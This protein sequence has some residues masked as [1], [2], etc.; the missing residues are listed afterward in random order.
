MNITG[1]RPGTDSGY[2]ARK[3][4]RLKMKTINRLRLNSPLPRRTFLQLLR[5][6]RKRNR[7]SPV[8]SRS[9]TPA[10]WPCHVCR[11]SSRSGRI[12]LCTC[13]NTK[14][15]RGPCW[16]TLTR[17][18]MW[19]L[20]LS[21]LVRLLPDPGSIVAPLPRYAASC[22]L[23]ER[24]T[25]GFMRWSR[26]P[27]PSCSTRYLRPSGGIRRKT[28]DGEA[29]RGYRSSTSSRLCLYTQNTPLSATRRMYPFLLNFINITSPTPTLHH[30]PIHL[31]RFL[32][33]GIVTWKHNNRCSLL[34]DKHR[35]RRH[36]R[37]L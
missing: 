36:S 1:R 26:N 17:P 10:R 2:A 5:G 23:S 15:H 11:W 8:G 29:P 13:L 24:W 25:V 37:A 19:L 33:H 7:W 12:H 3:S 9:H 14:K 16:P 31:S 22:N 21:R 28:L 18:R 35:R 27:R 32:N 4:T 34:C 20:L 30:C 6:L